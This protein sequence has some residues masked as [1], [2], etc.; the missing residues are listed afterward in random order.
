M[1]ET[2]RAIRART[3]SPK[4]RLTSLVAGLT[5][6]AGLSV[7]FAAAALANH[8]GPP[9]GRGIA[10]EYTPGNHTCAELRPGTVEFK[11]ENPRDGTYSDGTLTVEIDVQDTAAGPVFEWESNFSV[12]SIFVKG[13]PNGNLYR[14]AP[15]RDSDTNLHSPVNHANDKF[16]GLS[17][18]SFCYYKKA[19]KSGMK[20]EDKD[21]DGVKD[22][23]E[24]GLAGWKIHLFGANDS[25]HQV[26]TTDAE[27]KYA[28]YVKPG[29]YTVCEE[30]QA[31]W[32]QSYPTAGADCSTHTH[33]GTSSPGA[34]GYAITLTSGQDDK[35]NDFGNHKKKKEGCTPGFWKNHPE[36]WE[37]YST[38]Q[39]LEAVFNVPD[40]F[41]LDSTTL[42]EAL[43]FGGG[44]GSEGAARILLRASVA[45]L[46]NASHSD[47]SFP[48]SP[49]DVIAAVN[50]ALASGDRATMLALAGQ[51]D[52]DNNLGCP[53]GGKV[54]R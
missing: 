52:A 16:Y 38:G 9:S 47:V 45:A 30:Q 19:K 15:E 11:I 24:P 46:L 1:R 10:P 22:A 5:L 2:T 21:G 44:N 39:T 25:D 54:A 36:A 18:L 48:R 27:G 29:S 43:S 50:T 42:L 17:H 35:D 26:A 51:L 32:T 37:G 41:G 33:G 6:I 8:A 31:G 49:A 28:F 14:Y 13:G 53:L 20:F 23:G 7:V 3:R 34:K 4:A 40:S 12:D